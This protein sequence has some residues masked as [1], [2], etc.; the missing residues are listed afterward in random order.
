MK[1]LKKGRE[2][3]EGERERE[4]ERQEGREGGREGKG[5]EMKE[6]GNFRRDI[7]LSVMVKMKP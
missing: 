5:K 7:A 2:R 6:K 3:R 1:E 4:E